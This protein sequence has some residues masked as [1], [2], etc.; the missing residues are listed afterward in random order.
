MHTA[1]LQ[2]NPAHP[3]EMDWVLSGHAA[4]LYPS[5]GPTATMSL[6]VSLAHPQAD[7]GNYPL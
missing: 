6:E 7:H 5:R 1:T 2:I 4:T 3:E